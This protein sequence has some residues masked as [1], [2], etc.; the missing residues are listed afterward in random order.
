MRRIFKH[1]V[2]ILALL[3]V[4]GCS[5]GGCSSGCACAGLTPLAEG[6]DPSARIEN[7]AA[8]RLT[9]TGVDF[10][11]QNLGAIVGAVMGGSGGI[12]TFPVDS[13]SGSF[14][15]G[16]YNLCPDGP[17]ETTTP[18]RC[19]AEL[20]LGAGQLSFD[21]AGPHDLVVSGPLPLRVQDLPIDI[22]WFGLPDDR[23]H[24]VLNGNGVCHDDPP[25]PEQTFANVQVNVDI[26]IEIDGD[27]MH[28]RWG[29]SRM[30]IVGLS[31]NNADL[32]AAI[33]FCGGGFTS[34]VFNTLKPVM[35]GLMSDMIIGTVRDTIEESLC[36][37]ANPELS[38]PCPTGTQD[39]G[40]ICRY[41]P[42]DT[43]ECASAILGIEGNVD[44][45]VL[46]ASIGGSRGSFDLLLAAGGHTLRDDASGFHWGDLNPVGNGATIG[47]YGGTEPTPVS[48]C[49]P[50]V[51]VDLPSGIAI[52]D[53]LVVNSVSGWPGGTPG[54][55]FEVA[56]SERF[57]NYAL[58][59]MY[60]AGALCLG[61][62]GEGIDMLNSNLI[63]LG[64]GAPSMVELGHMK[65]PQPVAIVTRPQQ[66]PTVTFGNGRDLA[67]DPLIRLV[68][69]QMALDFYVWSLDRYIRAMTVTVDVD[70]PANLVVT[71]EGLQPVV[72]EI[73]INNAVV[74]NS[75]L[76]REDPAIIAGQL[77]DLVG[78]MVG[79]LLGDSLPVIDLNAE[80]AALGLEL[81]IPPTVEGEGSPGLRRLTKNNDNYLGIFAAF[82][83]AQTATAT[84]ADTTADLD[85]WDPGSA[86]EGIEPSA[87]LRL[88]STLD[89]GTQAVQWQV[90]ID[91]H[92]WRPFT[93]SRELTL[94]G[95]WLQRPGRHVVQVR[96]RAARDPNSLDPTPATVELIVEPPS[97]A[98]TEHSDE[99]VGTASQP[100][101]RGRGAASDSSCSCRTPRRDGGAGAAAGVLAAGL[102]AAVALLRR[103]RRRDS[104][105]SPQR[106]RRRARRWTDSLLGGLAVMLAMGMGSG[107]SCSDE[108]EGPAPGCRGRGDCQPLEPG[109]IGAYTSAALAPDGTL[110]VAGYLEANWQD[111]FAWGDLVVGR[112]NGTAVEW[113]AVDGVP[114]EPPADI[115]TY[116]P[117]GFRGGQTE[118][119]DDVGLWTS[120]A[121]DDAGSPAV[122]YYDA[123]HRALRYAHLSPSGWQAV[124]VDQRE[125]ADLGRY[126]KLLFVG[127][128]PVISYLF[129][130]PG[131]AGAVHS[132]VRVAT[133]TTAA[134]AGAQWG[135]EDVTYE[136]ATPCRAA[137]CPAGMRCVAST[138]TCANTATGCAECATGEECVD[139]GGPRCE[140]V[141]GSSK[142]D[143]YPEALGLYIS[144]APHPAGGFGLA[145]YDRIHG[146]LLVASRASG[147][148]ATVIADG[149]TGG[150]DTGDAG[151][152]ASLAIDGAGHYHVAYVEGLSEAVRYVRVNDGTTPASPEVVDTGAD[153][154]GQPFSDGLHIVGDD[155]NI[156]SD[157]NEVRISYQDAT[158]GTLR[159]AV[160]TP[161]ADQHSWWRTMVAQD[162]FAGAFSRQV[163]LGGVRHIVSFWRVASPSTQGNVRVV[164]SP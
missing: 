136:P 22:S 78:S 76:L 111:D 99:N 108:T 80:L 7:V 50:Q 36:Q 35:V 24:L 44:L 61:I 30:R 26:S 98:A 115:E 89:D 153:V 155:T 53:E 16:T 45:G 138:G 117:T 134:A 122:A 12:V 75:Q 164:P 28:S 51:N 67:T 21:V 143:S 105:R 151:M 77:Q 102:L 2:V 37:L 129:I 62:T 31:V 41:G 157:G 163:D 74:E 107:C 147:S 52:P 70:V 109:L 148:W 59:Q 135:F 93:S 149:E 156:W 140:A 73:G 9:D 126:A 23:T 49:V 91:R 110:W 97:A 39:V 40:G 82:G 56:I 119:G 116:D 20:D 13:S 79:S 88:G 141:H 87:T 3:V 60:N 113:Q 27:S 146:N 100:L 106:S 48:P 130:E 72:D 19:I 55:H 145:F 159:L 54:P 15:I 142:L 81:I 144:A 131:P 96:S 14:G 66:P 132:G 101:I 158:A 120:I 95:S 46:L 1:L 114:A 123:T 65:T 63:G 11:E 152:A 32:E 137:F 43:D 161:E 83:V 17:D 92:P 124:V 139:V 118:P 85:G 6:F 42:N 103:R 47:M 150:V 4:A 68:A 8:V 10:I 94:R 125:S 160:G 71:P 154:D 121:I 128:L 58:A 34:V 64:I 18:P 86:A 5:G 69:N 127:G 84:A 133:G 57:F 104:A 90:R 162:G 112:Y 33:N 29:Y 38:P 25:P